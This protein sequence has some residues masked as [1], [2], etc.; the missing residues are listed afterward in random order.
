M[1][2]LTTTTNC[3]GFLYYWP[4]LMCSD[5]CL[6]DF[7]LLMAPWSVRVSVSICMCA[8]VLNRCVLRQTLFLSFR[9][10]IKATRDHGY[11]VYSHLLL[12]NWQMWLCVCVC[13]PQQNCGQKFW[14]AWNSADSV[15]PIWPN[16]I[17]IS[18]PL[19]SATRIGWKIPNI[20]WESGAGG[21]FFSL[22]RLFFLLHGVL[23]W[24]L[25]PD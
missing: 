10:G 4:L 21:V 9:R 17:S 22:Q 11:V 14:D 19:I 8:S 25:T 15:P 3:W 16:T 23:N 5:L 24:T 2:L 1:I 7:T 6:S 13:L 12:I 18:T 20:P